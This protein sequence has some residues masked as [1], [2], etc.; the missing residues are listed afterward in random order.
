MDERL[1]IGDRVRIAERVEPGATT[2]VDYR[3]TSWTARNDGEAAI[4][5]GSEAEIVQV[6]RLTLHVR[7]PG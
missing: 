5:A 7:R 4:E 1:T 3:G 6:E 2:R